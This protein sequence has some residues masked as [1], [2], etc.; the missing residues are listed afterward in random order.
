MLA[1]LV[2]RKRDPG[3]RNI[4]K[5]RSGR[6]QAKGQGRDYDDNRPSR[7]KSTGAELK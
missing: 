1:I 7:A 3:S 2:E 4:S 5:A 6:V